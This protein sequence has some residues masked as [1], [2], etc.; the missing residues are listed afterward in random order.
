MVRTFKCTKWWIAR[1][2]AQGSHNYEARRQV[3]AKDG[4]QQAEQKIQAN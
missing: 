4:E 1:R 3:I 2:A